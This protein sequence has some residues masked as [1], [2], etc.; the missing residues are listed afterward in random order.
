MVKLKIKNIENFCYTLEND[1]KTYH[2]VLEFYDLQMN[3]QKGDIIYM[4]ELLLNEDFYE[5]SKYYCFGKLDSKYGR[6]A[7]AE[8][9]RDIILIIVNQQKIYLK[10]L[11]G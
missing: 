3:L 6:L 1:G 8:N 11:Y 2:F 9:E 10:R 4:H 7:L 5:Y